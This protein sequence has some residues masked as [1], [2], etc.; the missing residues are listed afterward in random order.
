MIGAP[1][2]VWHP[3]KRRERMLPIPVARTAVNQKAF[4]AAALAFLF[5]A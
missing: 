5:L 3:N 2:S 4:V 1:L